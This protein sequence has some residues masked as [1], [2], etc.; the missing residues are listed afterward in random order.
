VAKVKKKHKKRNIAIKFSVFVFVVYLFV[1]LVSLQVDLYNKKKEL[2]QLQAQTQEV[3]FKNSEVDNILKSDD[4]EYI[5]KIA[6]E[7]LGFVS[8]GE[9]VFVDVSGN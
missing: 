5:K 3:E 9:R 7:K 6:R 8:P 4:V 2:T 1:S